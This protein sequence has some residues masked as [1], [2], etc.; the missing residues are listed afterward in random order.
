[1]LYQAVG[2]SNKVLCSNRVLVVNVCE[3]SLPTQPVFVVELDDLVCLEGVI[4][5]L[6]RLV[7]GYPDQ[8]LDFLCRV[9]CDQ[10]QY[11]VITVAVHTKPSSSNAS[12]TTS[13]VGALRYGSM[14]WNESQPPTCITTR[15][16]SSLSTSKR[17]AYRRRRSWELTWR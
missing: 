9:L 1:M 7:G 10:L 15:G 2:S 12:L 16:F 13:G 4:Q 8:F 3:F 11:P 14:A 6:P 5:S 17:W